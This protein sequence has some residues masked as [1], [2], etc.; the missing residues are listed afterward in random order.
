MVAV[1]QLHH[2]RMREWPSRHYQPVFIT[3]KLATIVTVIL[4]YIHNSYWADRDYVRQQKNCMVL[5][6]FYSGKYKVGFLTELIIE[7]IHGFPHSQVQDYFSVL[8]ISCAIAVLLA[9][10]IEMPITNLSHHY[11]SRRKVDAAITPMRY[12]SRVKTTLGSVALEI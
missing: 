6:S 5:L 9:L 4:Q 12:C 1:H 2:I 11:L 8:A 3:S 10:T 7:F